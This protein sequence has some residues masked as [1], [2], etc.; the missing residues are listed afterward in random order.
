M[1]AY[2]DALV[3]PAFVLKHDIVRTVKDIAA[4]ILGS[5]GG[6]PRL[7]PHILRRY[8]AIP[9]EPEVDDCCVAQQRARRDQIQH[10]V[11][12]HDYTCTCGRIWTIRMEVN[13]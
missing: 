12:P 5:S 2:D 11:L 13:R 8:G 6:G 10:L 4:A 3:A 7:P 1:N 9:D